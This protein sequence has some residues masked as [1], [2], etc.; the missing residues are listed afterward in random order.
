M[1]H[2]SPLP[3]IRRIRE[4]LESLPPDTR[5][6]CIS[7]ESLK[8]EAGTQHIRDELD[9]FL[10]RFGHF[11]ES[12]NDF[13]YPK[14]GEDPELVYRMILNHTEPDRKQK[15]TGFTEI[16]YNR[17]LHPGLRAAYRKAGRFRTYREQI[18]S[19]Y[20]YGYGLFRALFLRLA[21]GFV[22]D[23]I[24]KEQGDIFYL[25]RK[26][27]DELV[28]HRNSALSESCIS[29]VSERKQS[30]EDSRDLIL[31]AVIYGE[32]AP[33]LDRKN[34]RNFRGTG[35]SPGQYTGKVKV[36]RQAGDFDK[37]EPGDVVI[38][39]FSDVSWTPVLCRSGAI[40]AESGGMLS[41]CSIIARELGLPS[42]VS[43]DNACALPDN[44][45]VTVD[46]SNGILTVHD[47]E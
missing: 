4:M 19:L 13:S 15:T 2:F 44:I 30:M 20:I 26:E 17:W 24:L 7:P 42:M 22:K 41:H 45:L 35:T 9:R 38:I 40:V 34:L 25:N 29:L 37:V 12:G 27:I 21:D 46:G 47:H 31:P 8:K 11:S 43:V 14:W 23:G 16:R 10:E 28:L 18:S 6:A 36:V 32:V 1:E 33:I 3:S 39:P 5:E